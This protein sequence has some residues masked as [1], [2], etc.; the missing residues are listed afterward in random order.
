MDKQIEDLFQAQEQQ[1]SA[2][3]DRT[4]TALAAAEQRVAALE[5]TVEHMRDMM[6]R[7]ADH[8]GFSHPDFPGR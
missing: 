5:Q 4:T 6:Q 7:M 1:I 3:S 8:A 2:L